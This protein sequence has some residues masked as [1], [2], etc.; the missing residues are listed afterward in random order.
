MPFANL[1]K[2]NVKI[3]TFL[4]FFFTASFIQAQTQSAFFEQ[5]AHERG[6][7]QFYLSAKS[8]TDANKNVFVAGATLNVNGNYDMLLTKY[9]PNGIEIWSTLYNGDFQGNDYEAILLKINVNGNIV[10]VRKLDGVQSGPDIGT[11]LDCDASGNVYFAG[12]TSG[13]SSLDYFI[14]KYSSSGVLQWTNTY[15]YQNLLLLSELNIDVLLN[16][17]PIQNLYLYH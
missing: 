12:A 9:N 17:L 13:N 5:W 10:W 7:Q 15:D 14:S 16:L 6:E 8:I 4:L 2:N 3:L 1:K 11:T